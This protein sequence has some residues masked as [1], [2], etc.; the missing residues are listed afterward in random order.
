MIRIL[1]VLKPDFKQAYLVCR[2]MN[3]RLMRNKGK[4]NI[5]ITLKNNYNYNYH[6]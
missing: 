6:A 3:C 5:F 2:D 1:P 4:L